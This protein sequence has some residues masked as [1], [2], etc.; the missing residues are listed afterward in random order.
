[1]PD[2]VPIDNK[3]LHSMK[4][5]RIRRDREEVLSE[6]D[7]G[8]PEDLVA[9]DPERSS[10]RARQRGGIPVDATTWR[11][12]LEAGQSV[13]LSGPDLLTSAGG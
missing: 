13:G 6:V 2:Q 5:H 7:E 11:E 3:L 12:I 1:M 4:V 10:T 8:A 9:G